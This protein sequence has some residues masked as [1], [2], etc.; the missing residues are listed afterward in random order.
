MKIVYEITS[1]PYVIFSGLTDL[2]NLYDLSDITI[3]HQLQALPLE[4]RFTIY[5][6]DGGFVDMSYSISLGSDVKRVCSKTPLELRKKYYKD[7]E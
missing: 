2:E 3:P 4:C 7:T 5:D 6:D 1:M